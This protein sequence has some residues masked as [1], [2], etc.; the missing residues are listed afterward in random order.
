MAVGA[1]GVISVAS[2]V[3]PRESCQMLKAFCR[4][5]NADSLRLH[6]KYYLLFKDLFIETN[7][8]PVKGRAAMMGQIPGRICLPLV[9]MSRQK[10][11]AVARHYEISGH[12]EIDRVAYCVFGSAWFRGRP[13]A[14]AIRNTQYIPIMTK[15]IITGSKGRMGQTLVACA[16]PISE[17]AS[18]R[19]NR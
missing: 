9:P 6:E 12:I 18:R 16:A 13:P 4:R 10:S 2:N 14:Q 15:L 17:A 3:I 1:Q 7:P 8:V 5:E 19:A 11:S